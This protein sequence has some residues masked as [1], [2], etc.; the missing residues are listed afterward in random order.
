[1]IVGYSRDFSVC[2]AWLTVY[3]EMCNFPNFGDFEGPVGKTFL[4]IPHPN[5]GEFLFLVVYLLISL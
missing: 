3:Q 2:S 4:G 1:M 5:D